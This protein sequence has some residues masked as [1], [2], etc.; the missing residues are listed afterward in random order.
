M[1]LCVAIIE[2]VKKN[3]M[4]TSIQADRFSFFV[5]LRHYSKQKSHHNSYVTAFLINIY[6]KFDNG[7]S[8]SGSACPEAFAF[9]ITC[10]S[11]SFVKFLVNKSWALI[12]KTF[13]LEA[14]YTLLPII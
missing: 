10:H 2:M 3:D 5:D 11:C 9:S 1:I 8:L 7:Y 4:R 6:R 14:K 13:I 12:P